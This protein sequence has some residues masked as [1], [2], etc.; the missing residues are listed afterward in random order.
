MKTIPL[1]SW[2]IGL[3]MVAAALL[4]IVLTPTKLTSATAPKVDLETMIPKQFGDWHQL[5][6]LDVISVSPEVQATIDKIYQQTLSRTYINSNGQQIMLA[7]AYGDN[8]A[9]NLQVHKP[10]QCYPAQGFQILH[11]VTG[12]LHL[13]QS[14]K[15]IPVK[16][17]VAKQGAR[18]EPITYWIT[19]GNQIAV[20]GWKWKLAQ[21]KYGLTGKVPDGMLVRIS[22]IGEDEKLSFSVQQNFINTMLNNMRPEDK[23]HLVGAIG[24]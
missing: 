1:K 11:S 10:E 22:S 14:Q 24:S 19:V 17:L 20:N 6:E 16:R 18:I 23:M 5:Q 15:N 4:S 13:E 7:L 12:S 21:L 8:Q 2:I 9:D 3:C